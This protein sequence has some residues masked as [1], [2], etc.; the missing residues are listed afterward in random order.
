MGAYA[1]ELVKL[2]KRVPFIHEACAEDAEPGTLPQPH[3]IALNLDIRLRAQ[4]AR[5]E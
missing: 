4:Q 2:A 3:V 1:K 5:G